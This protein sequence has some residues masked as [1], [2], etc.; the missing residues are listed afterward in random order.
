MTMRNPWL[1]LSMNAWRL[2]LESQAVISL[3]LLK[4]AGGGAGAARE[5]EIILAEKVAATLALPG[6]VMGAGLDLIGPAAPS[7]AI[8]H[9]RRKVRANQ[10]RLLR[11]G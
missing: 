6:Q 2:G 8:A 11:G 4:A 7:K 9:F 10:R 1:S 5:A 3:R